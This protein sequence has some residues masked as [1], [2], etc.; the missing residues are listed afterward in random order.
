[1]QYLIMVGKYIVE[2]VDIV[3]EQFMDYK[4]NKNLIILINYATQRHVEVVRD[5]LGSESYYYQN[6]KTAN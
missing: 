2:M 6:K 5:I 1:M 3:L 4:E